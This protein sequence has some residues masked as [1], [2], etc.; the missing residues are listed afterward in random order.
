LDISVKEIEAV[1][2]KQIPTKYKHLF[3]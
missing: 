3:N 2:R 1:L